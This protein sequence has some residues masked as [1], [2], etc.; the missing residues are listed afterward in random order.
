MNYKIVLR[1]AAVIFGMMVSISNGHA[2]TT[3][4]FKPVVRTGDA[5][6]VPAQ[7]GSV[8]EF[9][10]NDQAQ[11]AL[12][13]DGGLIL[14]SGNQITPIVAPGDPAPGGG[15]FV[16]IDAPVLGSQGQIAFR[17]ADT[18]PSSFGLFEFAN[19]A[20]TQ[21]IA[22]GA[23]ADNGDS[24]TP[25]AVKFLANGDLIVSDAFS[26]SLYL[27]SNN[28]L[29][30]L[31]GAGDIA[32]DG[33][34]F[35]FLLSAAANNSGQIAF[36]AFTSNGTD[37]IF[38]LSGGTV[39]KI[40]ASGD[41]FPDGV[42]FGF[43]DAPTINDLGQV[44]FGGISNSIADSGIFSFAN[45]QLSLPIQ[46]LAPLPDGSAFNVPLSTSVNN[47]GQIAFTAL[48]TS[49]NNTGVYLFAN[50]QIT[51]IAVTGQPAPDGGTFAPAT[52]VGNI[53]NNAGQIMF[54]DARALH[55]EALYLFSSNQIQRFIGQG[56]SI[57]RLP[58]F[59]FP[60]A[61]G[62][63]TGDLVLISDSTFP[64]GNGAYTAN[65]QHG[66]APARTNL[67][68]HVGESLG[69]DGV[70]SFL[71]GTNMNRHGQ[72]AANSSSG[73]SAT[74][75]I[76]QNNSLNIVADSGSAILPQTA[77]PA[78]NDKGGLAYTG[79]DPVSFG[80]GIYLNSKGQTKL[81]VSGATPAPGGGTLA[82]F[83]NLALSNQDQLAFMSSSSIGATGVFAFF[84]GTLTQLAANRAAAPGGGN[85]FLL[86]GFTRSGPVT[87]N[88][89]DVAF[90]SSLTGT[91]GGF[92]GSG[93]VFL[94]KNG[95]VTRIVGPDDPSPDGGVFLFAD[96]PS[97][98]SNGD[99]AFFAETSNFNFGAFVYSNGQISQVA[100]A[101][102]FV[103]NEG[104]GFV[105]L[106]IIND[107]GHIAFTATL[108]TGENAIFVAAPE[109]DDDPSL[110]DWT[111]SVPGVPQGA[112]RIKASRD[113]NNI[114][115]S[116]GSR[117]TS[118]PDEARKPNSQSSH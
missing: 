99:V 52:E 74:L 80:V 40:I 109:D 27:F 57:P 19:G 82:N 63:G 24:V 83:A 41:L 7:L 32:P 94:F 39:S 70:V 13:A 113:V 92:F 4:K 38:L 15:I 5:A 54:F 35:I 18:F 42:P 95:V 48:T 81:L 29:K 88:R 67:A 103:N 17:G 46:R 86:F 66:N 104:L 69:A 10:F 84:N 31:V 14:K 55:G 25:G 114:L 101:G 34:V 20:I 16:S 36:Q 73:S 1:I 21:L 6:P 61:A 91:D 62:I 89:G 118:K 56:D 100:V 58:T 87:D 102:D 60:T 51:G 53:I 112:K 72:V 108:F 2:Q 85:F 116:R 68:I 71:F 47:A 96:A 43:P 90:A 77:V 65:P 9:T 107:N 28:I 44:V 59:E 45:G 3:F 50:G 111:E 78:I 110:A 79:F 26:G 33:S 97:I 93:G 106:P 37:G 23:V 75:T 30:R 76:T 12:I 22:D 115:L 105:D 49:G 8:L 11:A 98:N 64:G 117:H